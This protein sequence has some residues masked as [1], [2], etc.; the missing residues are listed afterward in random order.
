[1][2]KDKI[3]GYYGSVTLISVLICSKAFITAPA[4]YA[5]Q[6]ASAGWL[7][8]LVSGLFEFIVLAIVLKLTEGFDGMDLVDIGEK[9]FG[10]AGKWAVGIL[11]CAV[12]VAVSAAMFRAFVE[13]VRNCLIESAPHDYIAVF[14]TAAVIV[15]AYLGLRTQINMIG[16]IVPL[17]STAIIVT[18]LIN[19]PRYHLNNIEP[20]LGN[21]LGNVFSNAVLRNSSYFEL[22]T[23]LFLTPYLG[24]ESA[25]KRTS[26]TALGAS[27]GVL[28]IMSLTYQLVIPYRAAGNFALPMYEMTRM[29]RAGSFFQ[30]I[31]PLIIFVWSGALF[32]YVG[33]GI[34][35][36]SDIFKKTF[37]LVSA[38]PTVFILAEIV[39]FLALIPGSEV[40]VEKIFD[41]IL[42][43]GYFVYPIAPAIILVLAR[44]SAGRRKG[45]RE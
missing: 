7:E 1:M 13:I 6:S 36:A 30:R 19:M 3:V 27:V 12:F 43:Y 4:F 14:I 40:N 26:F 10:K 38:R 42:E 9:A 29:I 8:V 11:S 34:W 33:A 15:G 37:G 35:F 25:V 24:S 21:G 39:C 31:E 18:L 41:V 28:A 32:V 16:L 23:I 20:I 2:R 44:W 17:L 5:R 45:A 22:G